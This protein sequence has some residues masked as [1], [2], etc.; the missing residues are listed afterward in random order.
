MSK[1]N[2]KIYAAIFGLIIVIVLIVLLSILRNHKDTST[3]NS[4][5]PL[6]SPT[7]VNSVSQAASVT[8]T[9]V[10]PTGFTGVKEETI[11][12]ELLNETKQEL[13][14]KNKL[15]LENDGFTINF[16]YS[17]DKFI[18][19]IASPKADNQTKFEQWLKANYSSLSM[20]RFILK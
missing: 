9:E 6:P 10:M 19:N 18:V 11:A 3:S 13:N 8:T 1:N 7:S 17:Q 15:P 2:L 5:T 12:P 16:D 4:I 14:L 20:G